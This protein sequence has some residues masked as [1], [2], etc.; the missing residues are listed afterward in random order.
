MAITTTQTATDLA[1]DTPILNNP[2]LGLKA[3]GPEDH[4]LF[5]GREEQA[6]ELLRR[7]RVTRFLAISGQSGSGKSSLVRSGL[8]PALQKG[9]VAQ[10][11]AKWRV[12]TFQPGNNPILNLAQS[13]AQRNV[14]HPNTKMEPNYPEH[15][16]AT[17]RRSSLGIVVTY[18]ESKIHDNLLIVVDQFEELFKYHEKEKASKIAQ[19]DAISFVNSLLVASNQR[20]YPI[21]IVIT[22]RSDFFG[23]ATE[24]RGLAE[25]IN[26]GQY[27][28]PRMKREEIRKAITSPI[29]YAG[30][31]IT[32]RLRSRLLNDVGE[33]ADQLPILQHALMRM[34]DH[35]SHDNVEE[36]LPNKPLD[37]RD[38]ESIGAMDNA[39]NKHLEEAYNELRNEDEKEV[40]EKLF[41]ALTD[42]SS[43]GRGVR[44]TITLAEACHI[45]EA[46]EKEVLRVMEPFRR[47]GR[48]FL[49][50]EEGQLIEKNSSISISHEVMMRKW[51]RLIT[52]V[53]EEQH[54]AEI[55]TRLAGAAGLYLMGK[56]ALW[57]DPELQIAVNWYEENEPNQAW[58]ARYN[59]NFEE[60]IDFLNKSK[61]QATFEVAQIEARRQRELE[62]SKRF[63]RI[64]GIAG[65]IAILLSLMSWYFYAKADKESQ[66]AVIEQA[67]AEEQAENAQI[68][69]ELARRESARASKEQEKALTA[70]E[71]AELEAERANKA[72]AEAAREKIRAEIEAKK[73]IKNETKA[74][75]QTKIAEKETERAY[76]KEKEANI[77]AEKARREKERAEALQKLTQA[78]ALAAKSIRVEDEKKRVKGLL[79][80][81]AY[82]A[83]YN[84]PQS[85]PFN[86]D[87][88]SGLYYGLRAIHGISFNAQHDV[89]T[90]AVRTVRFS[91]SGK[92][93]FTTGSDGNLLRWNIDSW[94][95]SK[96]PKTS[97][98]T[99]TSQRE[100]L[101]ELALSPNNK[102]LAIGGK[103]NSIEVY[104]LKKTDAPLKY[105]NIHGNKEVLQL[106]FL[107]DNNT[108][109]SAASD[110]TLKTYNLQTEATALL[111]S[112]KSLINSL[113]VSANGSTVAWGTKNG[114]LT[115]WNVS[116]NQKTVV[117]TGGPEITSLGISPNAEFLVAGLKET[118]SVGIWQKIGGTYTRTST[119]E[120]HIAQVNDISFSE[121]GTKMATASYDGTV[122]V[123]ILNS[124][125][126]NPNYQPMNLDDHDSWAM[127]ADFSKDG[128]YV[129]VGTRKGE[130][131]FWTL[132]LNEMAS[133]ICANVKTGLTEEE[134]TLYIGGDFPFQNPCK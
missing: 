48:H 59:P 52:W 108:L 107:S 62:S 65:A 94:R 134:K 130:L 86:G 80:A 118:G 14:L 131:K 78:S 33:D 81:E 56:A 76:Q 6:M 98:K 93:F 36:N 124:L 5:F 55:Y 101:N 44:R 99:L 85:V 126:N 87:I 40:C 54:S 57:R 37:I 129:V 128:K 17:L 13:I 121:D 19:T 18:Q 74:L 34:W 82:H 83:Y 125:R 45:V 73:A 133:E 9:F 112:S 53:E 96:K 69:A 92:Q 51:E 106:A 115:T 58:A 7:L 11:G 31:S 84:S 105:I 23:D 12:A 16:E 29:N 110:K 22:M 113:S 88:Y 21:Y 75:E 8:V 116:T 32:P 72:S 67:R 114:K 39:L 61:E 27:L 4:H 49:V 24:F 102:W 28:I 2:F 15:V 50:P 119:L 97:I 42:T 91:K 66:K 95:G 90:G 26:K 64:V 123:W 77:Q 3:F 122:R 30:A 103:I 10:A 35:W 43:D 109:I 20:D 127:S 71:L 60:A 47:E 117:T 38:Y 41:K 46:S 111:D 63:N 120:Q 70:A 68:A 100:V 1:V 132:E 89:H 104:D 79:A 25:S